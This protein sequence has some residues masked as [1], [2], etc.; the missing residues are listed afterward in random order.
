MYRKKIPMVV[1]VVLAILITFSA[2]NAQPLFQLNQS[3]RHYTEIE[4]TLSEE[5]EFIEN[6]VN[7][8]KYT[9]IYHPEANLTS[10]EGLPELPVFSTMIAVPETGHVTVEQIYSDQP[11]LISSITIYPSQGLDLV[12]DDKT[13]FVKNQAFYEKDHNYPEDTFLVS[14][15]AVLRD[16]RLV[17]INVTPFTYN[18]GKQELSINRNI[19]LRVST[20]MSTAGVNEITTPRRKLSR[21]FE[22]LYE[23]TI[24]N[25]N[26]VRNPSWEYQDRSLLVIHH[27]NPTIV[28]LVNQYVN[29]KRQKGFEVNAVNTSTLSSTTA[30]KNYIQTAYDT[31]DNPPEYVVI[32]GEG[33]TSGTLS[34]PH[35]TTY[36]QTGDTPYALLEGTDELPDIFLGRISV[37]SSTQLAT[38]MNKLNNYEKEPYMTETAW[39]RNALLVG[40][41]TTSSGI[42]TKFTNKYIKELMQSYSDDYTYDEVYSAPYPSQMDTGINAG[43][44]LFNFRGYLGMSGWSPS[45]ALSNG[46]KLSNSVFFTCSTLNYS[47]G[48]KVEPFFRLGSPTVA[49]GAISSM[50]MTTSGTNTAQNNILSGGIFYGIFNDGMRTM[51]EALVR[52]KVDLWNVH[53]VLHYSVTSRHSHWANLI[54]DPSLDI[55]VDIPKEMIVSYEEELQ[56]GRNFIDVVVTDEDGLP[57]K[58]AWVTIRQGDDDIFT[59]GYTDENGEITHIFDPDN[60]GEVLLTVTKPDYIPHLGSFDL[61]G[62]WSVALE[63][64]IVNGEF[65]AGNIVD[66]V[67]ML[68][69][70]RDIA[71]TGVS[72]ALS[73]NSP[74]IEIIEN[75]TGFETIAPD[76]TAE[77][78]DAYVVSVLA[79]APNTIPVSFTLTITDDQDNVWLNK[80]SLTASGNN[81]QPI[82]LIVTDGDNGYLDPGQTS[83]LQLTVQNLGEVSL[84]DVYAVLRT[85]NPLLHIADTLAYI[86]DVSVG[87]TITSSPTNSFLVSALEDLITGMTIDLELY[88]YNNN[89]YNETKTKVLEIGEI[90]VNDPL[91]PCEYGYYIYG[92]EDTDYDYAPEYDWIEIAPSQGGSG[93][94]TG[95]T[96]D[97]NNNHGIM[98]MDLPFTFSFYGVDYDEVSIA[99]NGFI[100]FGFSE[101]ATQ[102]N[103]RLPGPMGPQPI[104]AAFWDNLSLSSGGVYTYYDQDQDIFIIQ[105]ENALNVSGSQPE[106]FQIILYNPELDLTLDDGLIKI[107]YKIFNNVNNSTGYPSGEWGNYSTIGIGDHTGAVGLEYTFANQY[108][109]AA[110]PLQNETALMIVGPKNYNDPFILLQSIDVFDENNSG[111]VD[112]GE[113][114]RIGVTFK[115]IGYA[116]ATDPVGIL[117]TTSPYITMINDS[118]EYYD[119]ETGDE[120]VNRE[121]FEFNVSSATPNGHAA[122]FQITLNSPDVN[123]SFHFYLTIHKPEVNFASYMIY[124]IDGNGDSIPDPGEAINLAL[125]FANNT[126]TDILDATASL[127]SDNPWIVIEDTQSHIG[128]IPANSQV[129]TAFTLVIDDDC[130]QETIAQ[131]AMTLVGANIPTFNKA[132]QIG[133]SVED[134]ILDFE[135]DDGGFVSNNPDGW[136]WGEPAGSAYIGDN[137]WAT[138]LDANYSDGANWT[139]DSPDY[140]ITPG[141]MLSFFHRYEIEDYWDGGNL[142]I[143]NDEGNTWQIIYPVE[144]Y[145][146]ANSNSGNSG[147]PNQPAYSGSSGGW[148][149]AN[150]DLENYFGQTARVRWHFG[151]GPWVNDLGWFIDA[152]SLTGTNPEY[153]AISG[154]I[155]L[156][157]SPYSVSEVVVSAGNYSVKPDVNGYYSLI[158]PSGDYTVTAAMTNHFDETEFDVTVVDLETIEDIDFTLQYLTP[159]E[160]LYYTIDDDTH[161]VELT[162]DYYPLASRENRGRN[163]GTRD[164][165]VVFLVNRQQ[166]SGA[167][168]VIATTDLETMEYSDVLP[169]SESVYRYFVVAQYP[170]GISA[171]SNEVATDEEPTSIE[172]VEPERFVLRQNYPNPFNPVTNISFSLPERERV[173]LNIYNIKGALVKTL[174][175]DYLSAGTHIVQWNGLNNRNRSVSS[176][177]Y[178]YRIEAGKH[179]EVRK[180]ILLK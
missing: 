70:Y 92:M 172:I 150:F 152:V 77:G 118:S 26:E 44:V 173:S 158:I 161:T 149:E 48:Q 112:A 137:V 35:W 46:Y 113:N 19:V 75:E 13:G 73:S 145:P 107:Q 128:I 29:W 79:N 164:D 8:T 63:E 135:D 59:T 25:Y 64:V 20:D 127:S 133:V 144:G 68:K 116:T 27:H 143:S 23:G 109:T 95:L 121:F 180:A 117:T 65:E 119:L 57:L 159:P 142:K 9:R 102:R 51:G 12:I 176:G 38:F 101:Q 146:T 10:Q 54:G 80:F 47:G 98:T 141:T 110:A 82:E 30:I 61:T 87:Q 58:D 140:L 7:E 28:P 108:P 42:S 45:D 14:D 41:V 33:G 168:E 174:V 88:F 16:F 93:V 105:W 126:N 90:T 138:I 24:L 99:A 60:N 114:V 39:Y 178:F 85:K 21:S 50:G 167:F 52:A 130:P 32:I 3:A 49:K 67:V 106:T 56:M 134:F 151:S 157:Q 22:K 84:E 17:G 83:G 36:D 89:G 156:E 91:G 37:N 136:Q 5:F 165:E 96:A 4:F 153:G 71:A 154:Q 72:A 162:W 139:L 131:L 69:N 34:I 31:W 43:A 74:Y 94:N 155:T 76:G 62:E 55:W 97:W 104:V 66:F 111:Y 148:V 103:Y 120:F 53:G 163:S 125:S 123:I 179:S 2:A 160:N 86:G 175:D 132:L 81:L 78:D 15:P 166:D 11:E 115:N 1:L 129:Q 171:R 177:V 6:L 124:E 122:N 40:A 170:H 18:P 169:Q 100:G 147:I